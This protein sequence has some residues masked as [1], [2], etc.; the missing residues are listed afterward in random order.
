MHFFQQLLLLQEEPK[1][2][3]NIPDNEI[4]LYLVSEKGVSGTK[5]H[6]VLSQ[7]KANSPR[8]C[9]VVSSEIK[10]NQKACL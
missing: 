8:V 9:K 7:L 5:T 4:S 1:V 6:G 2:G 10:P 3:H